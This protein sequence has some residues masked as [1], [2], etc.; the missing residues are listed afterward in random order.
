VD[1]NKLG[2]L[3]VACGPM[4]A[5]KTQWVIM[6]ALQ[7]QLRK[8][9]DGSYYQILMIRP[10][11]DTRFDD[12]HIFVTHDGKLR[13]DIRDFDNIDVLVVERGEEISLL[14]SDYDVYIFDEGHFFHPGL[15]DVILRLLTAGKKIYFAA[16]DY[17]F[18]DHPFPTTAAILLL[19]EAKIFRKYNQCSIC[20]HSGGRS[21]RLYRGRIVMSG[22]REMIGDNADRDGYSYIGVCL[23]CKLSLIEK[24][25]D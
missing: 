11:G 20:G 24:N 6:M 16:L 8:K 14:D 17:D 5:T 22:P 3:R 21:A 4:F 9:E 15:K 23:P 2:K 19:P 12:K 25:K 1:N 13:I 10:D 7:N 18:V